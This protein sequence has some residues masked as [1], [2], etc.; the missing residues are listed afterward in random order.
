MEQ[1]N[2][3]KTVI[4]KGAQKKSVRVLDETARQELV[5]LDRS[6]AR[7]SFL[8]RLGGNSQ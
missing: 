6:Q 4:R 5:K 3:M 1:Y 2:G 7:A 8:R